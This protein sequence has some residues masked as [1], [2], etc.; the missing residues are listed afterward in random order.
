M[1]RQICDQSVFSF[2]KKKIKG[3]AENKKEQVGERRQRGKRKML[4]S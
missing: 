1:S 4:K 2:L 3:K